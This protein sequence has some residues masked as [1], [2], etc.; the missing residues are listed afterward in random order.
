MD[1]ENALARAGG[2]DLVTFTTDFCALAD[3]V[4]GG[5]CGAYVV[6]SVASGD[7]RP[8]VSDLDLLFVAET[9]RAPSALLAAGDQLATA[10]LACPLRGVEAVLYTR[11]AV[12]APRH[13]LDYLLNVNAGR[14][15]PKRVATGG[16][17]PFWFLLD[18][19][20]A[21]DTALPLRPPAPRCVLGKPPVAEVR[22]ALAEALRWHLAEQAASPDAVLNACR[23]WYWTEHGAWISKSAAG[24]WAAD[25]GGGAVV[26]AALHARA[27]GTDDAPLD[28]AAA[29][30]LQERVLQIVSGV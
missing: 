12:A 13:P 6:G 22:I 10:A 24:R 23:A 2:P 4:L 11:D 18:L 27:A 17:P 25:G 20:A 14:S 29:S 21:A 1:V 30:K 5:L 15:I 3:A 26:A 16:D 28:P 8:G 7:A 9:K 19:A